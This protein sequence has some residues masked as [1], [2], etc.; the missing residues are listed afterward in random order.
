MRDGSAAAAAWRSACARRREDE[1]VDA[2]DAARGQLLLRLLSLLW[3]RL[4]GP[5]AGHPTGELIVGAKGETGSSRKTSPLRQEQ[6][7]GGACRKRTITV[8]R[9]YGDCNSV[10]GQ[11]RLDPHL[12]TWQSGH[13]G[14]VCGRRVSE[15]RP[16]G[17]TEKNADHAAASRKR[18]R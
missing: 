18:N 15:R 4:L 12:C 3:L 2:E 17:S 13:V 5:F 11:T 16:R 8:S 7:S 1:K 9:H 6:C 10:S 14:G